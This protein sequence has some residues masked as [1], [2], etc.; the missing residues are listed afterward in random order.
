MGSSTNK[1][2]K[3]NYTAVIKDD[4]L[5]ITIA[6]EDGYEFSENQVTE[7]K[8]KL[9]EIKPCDVTKPEVKPT[10]NPEKPPKQPDNNND[11]I[12]SLG[13][14]L[15]IVIPLGIAILGLASILTYRLVN[16]RK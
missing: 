12:V 10:P 4:I 1:V 6:P 2:D 8:Y 7:F 13:E 16:K 9:P 15:N 11:V 3:V 14:N 5:T